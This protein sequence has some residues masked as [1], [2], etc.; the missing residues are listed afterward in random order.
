MLFSR[1]ATR[2][3]RLAAAPQPSL[4]L[5]HYR[6]LPLVQS[7]LRTNN[8]QPLLLRRALSSKP[9]SSKSDESSSTAGTD[10]KAEASSSSSCSEEPPMPLHQRF[11]ADM[12][13]LFESVKSKVSGASSSAA[14][15]GGAAA[16]G[17]GGGHGDPS[18][19]AVVVREPTFWEKHFDQES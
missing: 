5:H 4:R 2:I 1:S 17:E 9:E 19:G 10:E 12:G 13:A 14:S 7:P 8:A 15:S 18:Q 3:L 11:M 16:G 6:Q